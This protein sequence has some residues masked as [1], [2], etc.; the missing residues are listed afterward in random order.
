MKRGEHAQ[1]ITNGLLST[2][3]AG[4]ALPGRQQ[5]ARHDLEQFGGEAIE[6]RVRYRRNIVAVSCEVSGDSA[7]RY[8][9]CRLL[10]ANRSRRTGRR[11]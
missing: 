8:K 9:A 10:R 11:R 4:S 6:L 5:A 3:A 1:P 7:A 2:G